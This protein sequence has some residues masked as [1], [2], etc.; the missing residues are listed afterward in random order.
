MVVATKILMACS[1]TPSE[2]AIA[3]AAFLPEKGRSSGYRHGLSRLS[4]CFQRNGIELVMR[5][6]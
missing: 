3:L 4:S 1:A 6:R 5:L 2:S